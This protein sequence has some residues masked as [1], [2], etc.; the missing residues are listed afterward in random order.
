MNFFLNSCKKKKNLRI[1]NTI[2]K[3]NK[4]REL[5]LP[6]FKTYIATVIK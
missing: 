5:T 4:V 3:K 6:D 2:L 1:I